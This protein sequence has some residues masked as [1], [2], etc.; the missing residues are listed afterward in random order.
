MAVAV[1]EA[2]VDDQRQ[3]INEVGGRGLKISSAFTSFDAAS[4]PPL[5]GQKVNKPPAPCGHTVFRAFEIGEM[6]AAPP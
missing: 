2:A 1:V 4:Y 5:T 6:I 3:R